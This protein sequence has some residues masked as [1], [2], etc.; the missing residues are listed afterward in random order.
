MPKFFQLVLLGLMCSTTSIH[1]QSAQQEL[2]LAPLAREFNGKK[3][4]AGDFLKLFDDNAKWQTVAKN[5][6]VFKFYPTFIGSASEAQLRAVFD[7]LKRRGIKTA[8]EGSMLTTEEGCGAQV[9]GDS[10]E[11]T[12]HLVERIHQFGGELDYL[13]M[14]EPLLHAYRQKQRLCAVDVEAMAAANV[15]R[16]IR[17]VSQVFP[18]VQIGDVEAI[19]LWKGTEDLPAAIARW[20]DAFAAATGRKLAFVD[21]DVGWI[22]PWVDVVGRLGDEMHRRGIP[23]GVI[24][25]GM[26]TDL[27]D[28]A[29][30]ESAERHFLRYENSGYRRPDRA[31]FQS[32]ADYPHQILPEDGRNT[33]TSLVLSYLRRPVSVDAQRVGWRVSGRLVD[34]RKIAVADTSVSLSSRPLNGP[35]PAGWGSTTGV[36]P[37]GATHASFTISMNTECACEAPKLDYFARLRI[38]AA[39]QFGS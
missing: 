15:L 13:V 17:E 27:S 38:R 28:E 12:T 22:L 2:W 6:S 25:N 7:N 3:W 35:G 31:I 24:Y 4:G 8:L 21:A 23:F 5:I 36:V 39:W 16:T 37:A 18:N 14:N 20:S 1:A 30:V 32:W 29:W 26:D 34:D 9:S 11:F 10:G 19:G 33:L